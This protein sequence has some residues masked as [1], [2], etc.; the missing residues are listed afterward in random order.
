M[1]IKTIELNSVIPM[2]YYHYNTSDQSPLLI[3]L[4]GY[5]D[6]STA[7]IRR[8]CP[9]N[10]ADLEVLA[11][12]GLFPVPARRGEV[13]KPAYAWYFAD[14]SK[15][16]V[17]MHPDISAKA[18]SQLLSELN[19][20]ARPK[21]LVGFSQGVFFIPYLL[22][23]IKNVCSIFAVGAAYRSEDYAQSIDIP[24]EA[25]HGTDDEV[26]SLTTAQSSFEQFVKTKCANGKFSV[27][28]GLKHTMNDESRKYLSD[29]LIET[30]S[31]LRRK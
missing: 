11:P 28:P 20:V 9:E 29:R 24:F 16:A 27:F 26:I 15:N 25:L 6:S 21:I 31:V 8:L 17:L 12:N 4:H 23:E 13:W 10:L 30:A 19:L 3:V 1:E 5:T 14:F 2:T 22:R 7:A 18:V